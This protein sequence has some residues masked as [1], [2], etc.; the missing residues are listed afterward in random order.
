MSIRYLEHATDAFIEVKASTLK[1]AFVKAGE[2]VVETTLDISSVEEKEKRILK[3]KG[4]DLRYL[5]FNWL[6]EVNF[7][8]ITEGF[9]IRRFDLSLQKDEEYEITATVF[10]EPIDLKKHNFKIEIKAPTFHLMEILEGKNVVMRFL[11]DL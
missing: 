2:S 3:V 7:Q 4:K 9:A 1:E 11:M 6:E 5:L 8:L 10:G